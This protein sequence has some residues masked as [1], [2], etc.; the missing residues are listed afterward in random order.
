M[1]EMILKSP[2]P[3]IKVLDDY[4]YTLTGGLLVPVTLDR[5]AGDTMISNSSIIKIYL[6]PKPSPSNPEVMLPA[7]DITIS[8]PQILVIQHKQ[9]TVIP[10][11]S[12]QKMEWT[13]TIQELGGSKTIQ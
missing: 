3:E 11:T 6:A 5:A 8:T 4:D 10:L 12:E 2:D 1:S 13:R 7:E 9:R